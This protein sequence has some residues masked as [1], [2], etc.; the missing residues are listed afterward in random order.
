MSDYQITIIVCVS[1]YVCMCRLLW[2]SLLHPFSHSFVHWSVEYFCE[3]RLS[4]SGTLPVSGNVTMSNTKFLLLWSLHGEGWKERRARTDR[5]RYM[6][7]RRCSEKSRMRERA[8]RMEGGLLIWSVWRA[9]SFPCHVRE[10]DTEQSPGEKEMSECGGERITQEVQ[11]PQTVAERAGAAGSGKGRRSGD[12]AGDEPG[13]TSWESPRWKF[14][15][16]SEGVTQRWLHL[17]QKG[18]LEGSEQWSDMNWLFLKG[19]PCTER[20]MGKAGARRVGREPL[21]WWPRQVGKR[22]RL[23]LDFEGRACKLCWWVSTKSPSSHG[24]DRRVM[25]DPEV[26]GLSHWRMASP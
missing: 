1:A 22:V 23:R 2:S 21:N 25:G 11:H 20:A 26:L 10:G 19:P 17:S 7:G 24:Y 15:S 4:E 13:Q 12:Q 8:C 9:Y 14:A 18:S 5:Q 3:F 16:K 6:S